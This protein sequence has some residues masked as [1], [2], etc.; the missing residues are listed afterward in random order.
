VAKTAARYKAKAIT[1]HG[2]RTCSEARLKRKGKKDLAA[3]SGGI[4]LRQNR[5]AVIHDPAPARI[6]YP[7][8]DDQPIP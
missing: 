7:R 5:R 6:S 8:A 2:P 1:G 3:R 4:P